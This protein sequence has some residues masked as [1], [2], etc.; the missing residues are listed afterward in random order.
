MFRG[1]GFLGFLGFLGFTGFLGWSMQC[2]MSG[3]I[4]SQNSRMESIEFRVLDSN[5]SVDCMGEGVRVTL[6][7]TEK[8]F[9]GLS[10]YVLSNDFRVYPGVRE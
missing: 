8:R 1:F 3:E 7:H 2:G 10:W 5:H 9:K 6:G 4:E